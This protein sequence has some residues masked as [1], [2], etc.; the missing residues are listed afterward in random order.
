MGHP[1]IQNILL[2][3]SLMAMALIAGL[4]LAISAK[5]TLP[6][7][8]F[9]NLGT[10]GELTELGHPLIEIP[11]MDTNADFTRLT[12]VNGTVFSDPALISDQSEVLAASAALAALTPDQTTGANQNSGLNFEVATGQVQ[13]VDLNG[14]LNLDNQNI[15]L[16]GGG[17]LVL[18]I[19]SS[20]SLDGSAGILGNPDDIFI[21]YMGG[22][23]IDTGSGSTID[24]LVLDPSAPAILDGNLNRGFFGSLAP[25]TLAETPEPGSMALISTALASLIFVRR[26]CRLKRQLTRNNG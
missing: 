1:I 22:S 7:S 6:S 18:N 14:G 23:A 4:S 15:T 11:D 13:V 5:A 10:P 21:N 20:F 19:K 25:E 12:V 26:H 17:G 24:G 16:S 3:A 8:D 2:R 9:P